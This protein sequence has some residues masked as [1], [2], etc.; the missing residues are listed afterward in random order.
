MAEDWNTRTDLALAQVAAAYEAAAEAASKVR[1]RAPSM[2]THEDGKTDAAIAIT[3]LTP[4]DAKAALERIVKEA[5]QA[6][7]ERWLQVQDF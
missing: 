3:L 2:D 1:N 6:E 7:R 5:V 4:D